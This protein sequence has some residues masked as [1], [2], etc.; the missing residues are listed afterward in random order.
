MFLNYA[1][2]EVYCF[3]EFPDLVFLSGIFG[4]QKVVV[5]ELKTKCI[6]TVG[7]MEQEGLTLLDY[8]LPGKISI[9]YLYYFFRLLLN[10]FEYEHSRY[11]VF[12]KSNV[13]P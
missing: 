4:R 5:T 7:I 10:I 8:P 11:N 12:Q 13:F 6:L 2:N 1:T 9:E 3:E